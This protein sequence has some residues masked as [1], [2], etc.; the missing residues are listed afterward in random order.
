MMRTIDLRGIDLTTADLRTLVP[1]PVVNIEVAARA[2]GELIDAV[3]EHGADALLHQSERFDGVRPSSLRVPAEAISAAVDG[4]EPKVRAALE[5]AIARVRA[6]SAAQ[7]PAARSTMLADG[8]TVTQR[9]QPVGRAG[10]YV[11]GGKAPTVARIGEL[12]PNKYRRGMD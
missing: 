2:A 10:L 5:E 1:R 6:G 4:V 3:R 9:W 11:P 8:A 12:L 7:V